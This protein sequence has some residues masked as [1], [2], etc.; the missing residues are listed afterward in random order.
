LALERAAF[1]A[2]SG[3]GDPDPS[4]E[5]RYELARR[6]GRSRP[7]AQAAVRSVIG[8]YLTVL[9]GLHLTDRDVIAPTNPTRLLRSAIG[10]ALLVIVLGGLVAATAIVNVWPAAL[11]VLASLAV[12]TPVSKGTAR[13]VVGLVSFP[14]AWIVAG[15]LT[16]DGALRVS[17]VVL[18]SAAGALAAVWLVE[19]A[20]ALARMLLRWQ[21]QR[22]RV[23]TVGQVLAVRSEVGDTVQ[24][25]VTGP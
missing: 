2:L 16:A 11:V 3:V 1:V 12:K 7:D 5:E 9:D 10:I 14:I 18:T 4:L 24:D 6:L 20:M 15:V 19:R 8:R 23:G 21:A 22:E 17:L 25:A 13:V